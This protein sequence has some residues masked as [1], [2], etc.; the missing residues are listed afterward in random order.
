MGLVFASIV[1]LAEASWATEGDL[2]T[3]AAPSTEASPFQTKVFSSN[4]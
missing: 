4:V 2:S 1:L 3:I